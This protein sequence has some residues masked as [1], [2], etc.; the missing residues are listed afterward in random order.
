MDPF[1]AFGALALNVTMGSLEVLLPTIGLYLVKFHYVR[2]FIPFF[3]DIMASLKLTGEDVWQNDCEMPSFSNFLEYFQICEKMP[4]HAANWSNLSALS[5]PTHYKESLLDDDD[6]C[7]L[8][9]VYKAM[10]PNVEIIKSNLSKTI[11][12]YGTVSIYQTQFGSKMAHRR[13]RSCFMAK[14]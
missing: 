1:T 7:I 2:L 10:I 11:T 6:L 9:E 4:L 13:K 5:L 14:Q 3:H 12:K 8:L